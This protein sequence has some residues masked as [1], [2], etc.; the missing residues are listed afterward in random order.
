MTSS[1]LHPSPSL[2]TAPR[3]APTAWS[4]R[5][6]AGSSPARRTACACARCTPSLPVR[7]PP[8]GIRAL[9]GA[10]FVVS[11]IAFAPLGPFGILSSVPLH[12]RPQRTSAAAL[13]AE[14]GAVASAATFVLDR[15]RLLPHLHR[16]RAHPL[17]HLHR[18]RAR[19]LPHLHRGCAHPCHICTGTALAAA[20]LCS[21]AC[22]PSLRHADRRRIS[23]ASSAMP[24]VAATL[25]VAA[26]APREAAIRAAVS[27]LQPLV[28][29]LAP[30]K[31][32]AAD[33][34]AALAAESFEPRPAVDALWDAIKRVWAS[35][36][37]T[38]LPRPHTHTHPHLPS[39]LPCMSAASL[40]ARACRCA[41]ACAEAIAL[42]LVGCAQAV[43]PCA[44]RPHTRSV[45]RACA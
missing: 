8:C 10:L 13:E 3:R 26:G 43:H 23:S 39:R 14:S 5:S 32:V 16:D 15:A 42:P 36:S 31:A 17:P 22:A 2:R 11:L 19:L 1:G 38:P 9:V 20:T 45:A 4:A 29:S 44:C 41:S 40:S 30:T 35:K 7:F 24:R 18:D 37:A 6:S 12:N 34:A 28:R 21:S 25:H 27:T 33:V